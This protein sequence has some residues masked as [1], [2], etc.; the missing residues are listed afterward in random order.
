MPFCKIYRIEF[1]QLNLRL[2]ELEKKNPF[3]LFENRF[4][5]GNSFLRREK[6][7]IDLALN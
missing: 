1:G 6:L 2:F 7:Q 4:H 5:L 3:F